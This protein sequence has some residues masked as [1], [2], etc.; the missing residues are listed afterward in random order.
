MKAKKNFLSGVLGP[1]KF[2]V[3]NGEQLVSKAV[4][5]GTMKQSR[6]TK[7]ASTVFGKAASLSRLLR[8]SVSGQYAGLFGNDIINGLTGRMYPILKDCCDP[9]TGDYKFDL[10]SFSR[11]QQLEF[12]SKSKVIN[13]LQENPLGILNGDVLS[14]TLEQP[15]LQDF[16]FPLRSF[17]CKITAALSLFRL[18][19]QKMIRRA[20]VQSI[21]V[22]KA[23]EMTAPHTFSFKLPA[24][25]LCTLTLFMDYST[26]DEAGWKL[27]KDKKF[28]PAVI[29]G[30]YHT[31]GE[32]QKDVDGRFWTRT[33]VE[34]P[35]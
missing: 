26:I 6:A 18:K 33:D 16:K 14:L 22:E 19:D 11:L 28:S 25:C 23:N 24:G 12:N 32:Y 4:A 27:L 13:L 15:L 3:R 21:V 17:K 2:S 9:E 29:C 10:H 20:E 1:L 30:A 31:E 35:G 5:P 7:K 34:F 8:E